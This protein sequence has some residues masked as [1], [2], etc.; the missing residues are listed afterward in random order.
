MKTETSVEYSKCFGRHLKKMRLKGGLSQTALAKKS[1]ISLSYI[2][3]L[4]RGVRS[5]SVG[6]LYSLALALKVAPKTLL[7]FTFK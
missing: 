7:E 3:R 5:P 1:E 2:S 6:I 4:E